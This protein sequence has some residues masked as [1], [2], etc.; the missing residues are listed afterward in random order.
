[1]VQ[2]LTSLNSLKTKLDHLDSGKLKAV[3]KD[4]IKLKDEI[5]DKITIERLIQ[6]NQYKP[7][8]RKF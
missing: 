5:K 1:M 6:V 7:D 2:V 8:K 4:S 3:S